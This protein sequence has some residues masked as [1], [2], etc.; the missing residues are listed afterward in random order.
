M[1]YSL[2]QFCVFNLLQGKERGQTECSGADSASL[3][4]ANCLSMN[5]FGRLLQEIKVRQKNINKILG[6]LCLLF[7]ELLKLPIKENICS[8]ESLVGKN[9]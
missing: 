3:G 6:R 5:L 1:A 7:V 8:R 4:G 9:I 2:K